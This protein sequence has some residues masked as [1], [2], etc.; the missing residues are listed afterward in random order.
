MSDDPEFRRYR[1]GDTNAVWEV[2]D[3]AFRAAP[4][5]HDPELDRHLRHVERS[6]LDPGGEFLVATVPVPPADPLP[7]PPDGERIVAI[8]GF[9]PSTAPAA[10]V[11]P[12]SPV[13]ADPGTVE[14]KSVRVD[15]AF[16]RHGYARR[17]VTALETRARD[18]GFE[19]AVLDTGQDL[20]AAR[21]L[22]ES[23]GYDRV[24]RESFEEF[25]LVYYR[26]EI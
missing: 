2:H 22:Y 15:P 26:K 25:G 10:T 4:V 19:R 21:T 8:G 11:R 6:F 9:L 5:E 1:P 24:G 16:R 18:A 13:E 7:Y 14:V 17:L 3:R 20:S 12:G 23:L